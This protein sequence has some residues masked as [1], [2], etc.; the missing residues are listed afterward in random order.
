M[1]QR[2]QTHLDTVLE[3]GVC[4]VREELLARRVSSPAENRDENA[5]SSSK[6]YH[7]EQD[8]SGLSLLM[9]TY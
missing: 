6:A 7:H 3:A 4:A 2:F 8:N 5:E 9:K 1:K